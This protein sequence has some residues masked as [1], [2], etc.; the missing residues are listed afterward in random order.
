MKRNKW[1]S[2]SSDLTSKTE[3]EISALLGRYT[4]EAMEAI[5]KNYFVR[6]EILKSTRSTPELK[7]KIL[8]GGVWYGEEY[9]TFIKAYEARFQW[10][11]KKNVLNKGYMSTNSWKYESNNVFSFNRLDA[12]PSVAIIDILQGGSL[13]LLECMT[14]FN[15]A[16]YAALLR[17]WGKEKFDRVF[18]GKE[19]FALPIRISPYTFINPIFLFLEGEEVSDL[20]SMRVGDKM[21]IRNHPG[22]TLK[23]PY[24]VGHSWNIVCAEL[25]PEIRFVGFGFDG[26][27][28]TGDEV[29]SLL[30]EQYNLPPLTDKKVLA[31]FGPTN[32]R[33]QRF[34]KAPFPDTIDQTEFDL[35]SA[36]YNF[37]IVK[38]S[39]KRV[40]MILDMPLKSS[41]LLEVFRTTPPNLQKFAMSSDKEELWLRELSDTESLATSKNFG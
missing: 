23:H 2:K 12:S 24:G 10:M 33:R 32:N 11:I 19:S 35:S 14:V 40:K 41:N 31:G 5:D 38:L 22:Y 20:S 7:Q 6:R 37:E 27:R 39:A 8:K 34:F 36:G 17:I 16:Q 21:G 13:C 26:K 15:I 30:I 9:L 1:L 29:K 3:E 4:L 18:S 28:L 25:S